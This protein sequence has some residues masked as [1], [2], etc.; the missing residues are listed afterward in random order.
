MAQPP[1][2]TDAPVDATTEQLPTVDGTGLTGPAGGGPTGPA[3]VGSSIRDLVAKAR[4]GDVLIISAQDLREADADALAATGAVAV[5]N[6]QRT[7]SGRQPAAGARRLL[8]AGMTVID[9]AGAAVLAVRDGSQLT[10]AGDRILRGAAL[11]ATGTALTRE[12]VVAADT[13]ALD[14]L[15]VQVAVFGSHA[16]ERLEREG[17]L[18]FE[19]NGLPALGVDVSDRVVLVVAESPTTADDLKRLKLFIA[20]R[21][22]LVLA[23]G[24]AVDACV[25]NHLRPAVVLGSI[26]RA[27]ENVLK[28]SRV[29]VL[30]TDT[31]AQSRLEAMG[32][33]YDTSDVALTGADLAI[34]AAHHAG[35][36]VVVVA[37]R[38]QG[39]VDVLS[40][41]PGEGIGTFLTSL[42]TARTT[43]DARVIA[44][45]YRHRHSLAFV[46]TVVLFA[47]LTFA[48]AL[49]S[50]D[51]VR[52]WLADAFDTVT[53]WFGGAQ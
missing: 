36:Q 10:L 29:I 34:L 11:V 48:V 41:E 8:D 52:D 44:E 21:R 35:A 32:V 9:G 3:R 53:G 51:D 31:G 42:V 45:T 39:A 49:L 5:V 12:R 19:G 47:G 6:A 7:A 28:T 46:W 40:A 18:F 4:K 1:E 25:A 30:R 23:E 37:G 27:P 33:G 16:I 43:T 15:K 50:V 26:D 13:A 24:G 14:H 2:G 17:P 38:R 20:D 22:P